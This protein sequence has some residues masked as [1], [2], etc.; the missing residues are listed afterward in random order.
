MLSGY[1]LGSIVGFKDLIAAGIK[2]AVFR[3]VIP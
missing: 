3:N 2:F 1:K